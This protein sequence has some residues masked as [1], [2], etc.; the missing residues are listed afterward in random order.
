MQ[1]ELIIYNKTDFLTY[2]KR[3]RLSLSG[4]LKCFQTNL[5]LLKKTFHYFPQAKIKKHVCF[6]PLDEGM[7]ALASSKTMNPTFSFIMLNQTSAPKRIERGHM[8]CGEN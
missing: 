4:V 7:A 2:F 1:S 6:I 5:T 3:P 8:N